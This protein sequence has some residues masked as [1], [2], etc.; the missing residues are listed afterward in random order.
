MRTNPQSIYNY[1]DYNNDNKY[2]ASFTYLYLEIRYI[3]EAKSC[4]KLLNDLKL[5]KF[6]LK[7]LIEFN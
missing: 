2:L 1:N 3:N 7:V 6:S 5:S 4:R